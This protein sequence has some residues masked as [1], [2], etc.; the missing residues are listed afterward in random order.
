MA[1]YGSWGLGLERLAWGAFPS[2]RLLLGRDP[3]GDR[4]PQG[5]GGSKPKQPWKS[6]A[7]DKDPDGRNQMGIPIRT[8]PFGSTPSRSDLSGAATGGSCLPG[9]AAYNP[10]C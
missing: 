6:R 10:A 7:H 1:A 8:L 5:Y 9:V 2:S 3:I 4:V